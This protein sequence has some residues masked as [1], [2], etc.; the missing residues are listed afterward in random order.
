MSLTDID[1]YLD[2]ALDALT[3]KAWTTERFSNKL[4]TVPRIECTIAEDLERMESAMSAKG[5]TILFALAAEVRRAVINIEA[6]RQCI[7]K[8]NVLKPSP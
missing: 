2:D 6:A 4:I 8:M 5:K 7:E 1:S 3:N